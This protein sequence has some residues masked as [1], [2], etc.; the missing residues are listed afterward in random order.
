M[1]WL[2]GRVLNSRPRGRR[3]EPHR[4]HCIVVLEQLHLILELCDKTVFKV[5]EIFL[6]STKYLTEISLS[7]TLK[8]YSCDNITSF[9]IPFLA[10]ENDNWSYSSDEEDDKKPDIPN[11][12]KS[13]TSQVS[14]EI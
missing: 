12:L 4:C 10:E 1:Q 3:F 6:L 11:I 13:L 7:D 9:L 8:Y 2:I 14:G 5:T